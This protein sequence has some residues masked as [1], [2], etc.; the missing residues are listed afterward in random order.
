MQ[1]PNPLSIFVCAA[2]VFCFLQCTPSNEPSEKAHAAE[3]LD[4]KHFPSDHFFNQ[5]A[6]PD[7]A[8][9]ISAYTDALMEARSMAQFQRDGDIFTGD[10][11]VQGPG[12][13][14]GRIN[15][16]AIHPSDPQT[17]YVGFG[18]GGVWKTTDLGQNWISI[19]DD[20]TFLAIGD[21]VIDPN[22]PEIVYVGTGDP[23][24]SGYPAI[25]DG[26]YKSEDGGQTWTHLGL[27]ETRIISKI[28]VDPSN[29]QT[30][31]VSTMGL[32][33]EPGP[34]RGL[35]K[36][37][38][39]GQNWAQVLFVSEEAG[40]IDMLI[41][42]EQPSTLYAAGWDRIRNNFFSNVAGP[43]AR[44]YKTM[45]GGDT[46]TELANGLPQDDQ[47][48]IGLTM[49]G[50]NT[51]V[52]FA[53]YVGTNSQLYRIFKSVDAGAT[54]DTIPTN[55]DTGLSASALGGFGWYFGKIRVNPN[56]D[57]D[58]FLLGVDLWRTLDGGENWFVAS[59]PWWT[60]EV[61]ADK[62]D[63]LFAPE[64]GVYD[65]L[66]A[67]D[68]GLYANVGTDNFL[69]IED[70]PANDFYRV[71]YNPH[72]PD[73]Y[74][75]GM[76][77]NGSS[78]GNLTTINDWPRIFGGDG[79]QMAFHPE[80]PDV[81]FV[82]TQNGN[83]RVTADNG[84]SFDSA[85]GATSNDSRKNWDMPYM[86]SAHD[87]NNLYTGTFRAFKGTLDLNGQ[88]SVDWEAISEDITKGVLTSPR[89][90]TISTLHESPLVPGLL[91]YGASDGN[92]TRTE[93]DGENWEVIST[94]LPD[95]YVTDVKASP[96]LE[97]N[98]YVSHSGYKYNDFTPHIHR[99]K[100]RGQT[101]ESIAGD[102]PNLAINDVYVLPEH[103]DSI[104]FVATDGGV[105][106]TIDA[107]LSWERMG[108]SLPFVPV[109]DL[110]VNPDENTLIAGTFARSIMTYPL[111]SIQFPEPPDTMV[112]N[113]KTIAKSID[114]ELLIYP[115]LAK[116]QVNIEFE[117]PDAAIPFELVVLDAT[118]KLVYTQ[119][120]TT[121]GNTVVP[122]SVR[123]LAN[124]TYRVK[125]RLGRKM[126]SGS[127]I[128]AQ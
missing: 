40:V 86:I 20:Q 19:F 96:N 41:D 30:L 83:I 68:G 49:S 99:S 34:D 62:H 97:D 10:W 82:E 120:G 100:D 94:D 51:D 16:V 66:L 5:R 27:T 108:T 50:Q 110:E 55:E 14:G 8:F 95:R 73:Q 4:A 112:S 105:Y 85:N 126:L 2:I 65:Y 39:G 118:G 52:L 115:T 122:V 109:Y 17:I 42:P 37:T 46:W 107:G 77:D 78:G 124:G 101:W 29:T 57:D 81:F 92:L 21:I 114:N 93:D 61:H 33:F 54:W 44:I 111:D 88:P 98:V 67:T 36:S 24:I 26:L 74:Y 71:A 35:Y 89:Y 102:L 125:V 75:G 6:Y 11:T 3:I 128:K 70:I 64:G 7:T 119:N 90:H 47:G 59:P 56:N 32:P 103:A 31:Y 25:G 28:I 48:R 13:I 60:Y 80:L 69:D 79:F 106:G 1:Y 116:D 127:F 123:Y 53:E 38:D 45:D 58:I 43:G 121:N 9:D 87:P 12:N 15:T 91:Y 104:L 117:N 72:Q 84:N 22:N 76:Q 23:N 63:L 113:N 18:Q